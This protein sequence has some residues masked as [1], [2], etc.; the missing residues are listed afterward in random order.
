MKENNKGEKRQV[1]KTRRLVRAFE[2]MLRNNESCF[3]EQ[4]S[5]ENIIFFYEQN[6]EFDK[7]AAVVEFALEQYPYSAI[8]LIKKAQIAL[9]NKQYQTALD[10][11]D[12]A[13]I[14]SPT[15]ADI[16]LLRAEV[17]ATQEQFNTAIQLLKAELP[18]ISRADRLSYYLAI[19]DI[20]EQWGKDHK[21]FS[22]LK[23][24]L[25]LQPT[26]EEALNRIDY[27]AEAANKYDESVEL[28]TWITDEHPFCHWAWYN[29]GNAYYG[30]SLYEKAIEAYGFATAIDDKFDLAY[31]D[32]GNAYVALEAYDQALLQYDQALACN[33]PDDDLHYRI[34]TCHYQLKNFSDSRTH[35]LQAL[36]LNPVSA[37]TFFQLG[38]VCHEQSDIAEA[39][40]NYLCAI[41]I[42]PKNA[43]Y[44]ATLAEVYGENGDIER[45]ASAYNEAIKAT[46][47][48]IDYYIPLAKIYFEQEYYENALNTAWQALNASCADNQD[49]IAE[50]YCL[51][52]AAHFVLGSKSEAIKYLQIALVTDYDKKDYFLELMPYCAANPDINQLIAQC[53][54]N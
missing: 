20:Y 42:D 22:Y 41:R 14:L 26:N 2:K 6:F 21:V 29:L 45:A 30:L 28:H 46:D 43:D 27:C 25:R 15:D 37:E 9:E 38:A 8:F 36:K 12:H 13:A 16:V 4:N 54:P 39:I 23:R 10:L 48:A 31:R 32:S 17:Y 7:V 47:S 24:A 11:L 44:W 51:V 50:L 5:L 18:T 33:E 1:Q 19:A 53:S 35:L 40:S 34:G 3:F 49:T 52:A